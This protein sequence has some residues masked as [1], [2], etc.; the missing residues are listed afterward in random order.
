MAR[1]KP[2][3]HRTAPRPGGGKGMAVMAR[4]M[5]AQKCPRSKAQTDGGKVKKLRRAHPG[6]V[7]LREIK[8]CQKETKCYIPRATFGRLVREITQNYKADMRY[9]LSALDALREG[10][11]AYITD[12]FNHTQLAAIHAGRTTVVSKDMQLAR[13]LRGERF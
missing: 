1:T 5:A 8:K 11:E 7:A 6:T 2:Q 13:M 10:T 4:A 12:L 9:Q 3:A